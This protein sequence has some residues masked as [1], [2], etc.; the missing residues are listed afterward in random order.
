MST[1][2]PVKT[3]MIL[4]AG[5]GKRMRPLTDHC[6]KPLLK[7]AGKPLIVWH[8]EKLRSAGIRC[9][10]INTSYLAP[11]IH[12]ELGDGSQFN[13]SIR[14]SDEQPDPLETLGGILRALPLLG[15]SPFL[16]VNGDIWCEHPLNKFIQ[17]PV[18]PDYTRLLLTQNPPHHNKGDFCLVDGY[19]QCA[20]DSVATYT[21]TGVGIYQAGS[22]K[23]LRDSSHPQPL[24][25]WLFEQ[26]DKHRLLGEVSC[27]R[28]LDIGTPERLQALNQQLHGQ[29]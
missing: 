18:P 7:V 10:V 25:P 29:Q 24:G 22:F 27:Y 6:P 21:Y 3:A 13:V 20:S 19:C 1:D 15:T 8:I 11:N 9:I 17:K 28:W 12:T 26:A 5:Q 23:H 14:Y 4:A 16:V 2:L